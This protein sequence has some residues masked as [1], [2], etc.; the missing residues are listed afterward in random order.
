MK[1]SKGPRATNKKKNKQKKKKTRLTR[2][3]S[4]E[5]EGF[6]YERTAGH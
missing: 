4:T 1:K 3:E 2:G 5:P 6:Q